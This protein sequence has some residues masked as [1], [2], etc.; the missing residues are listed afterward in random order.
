MKRAHVL[1]FGAM[2]SAI[3]L[4]APACS[5]SSSS[6]SGGGGAAPCTENP[7]ACPTG[8]TCWITAT[9]ANPGVVSGA[10]CLN[11]GS[12]KE[13][14]T[15][16]DTPNA[17]T[18]GDGLVCL[19]LANTTSGTCVS[20]CDNTNVAHACAAGEMCSTIDVGG[21][22]SFEACVPETTSTTSTSTSTGTT[23]SSGTSTSTSTTSTTGAGGA[24]GKGGAGGTG[25]A[26]A[27]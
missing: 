10:Q 19:M 13:G 6:T 8:Q 22:L 16:L 15:C 24:G 4:L 3:G 26:D 17:P 1:L 5:S 27:G 7:F 12:G 25:G 18:C 14:G 21:S 2:S 11:S 23:T 9:A 20:Y